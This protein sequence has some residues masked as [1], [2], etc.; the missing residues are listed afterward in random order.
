[1]EIENLRQFAGKITFWGEID[2]QNL[3][4]TGTEKDI[5]DAVKLVHSNGK[6]TAY[7]G[8][9]AGDMVYVRAT[10]KSD[11]NVFGVGI[12]KIQ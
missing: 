12:I 9:K 3:L 4:L 5:D 11:P 7:S 10:L 1:M 8:I 2:R 6:F